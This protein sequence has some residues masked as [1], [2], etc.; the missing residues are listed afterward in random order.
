MQEIPFLQN[1]SP[2]PLPCAHGHGGQGQYPSAAASS[3][4]SASTIHV[5]VSSNQHDIVDKY[6]NANV[7]GGENGAIRLTL[8]TAP[9]D[10]DAAAAEYSSTSLLAI[11]DQDGNVNSNDNNIMP[12]L[13]PYSNT[14]ISTTVK[15][16]NSNPILHS[17]EP[18]SQQHYYTPSSALLRGLASMHHCSI[19]NRFIFTTG[20]VGTKKGLIRIS[21]KDNDFLDDEEEGINLTSEALPN[22]ICR[23][24][25]VD[26]SSLFES[27]RKDGVKLLDSTIVGVAVFVVS[28]PGA[29]S[30]SSSGRQDVEGGNWDDERMEEDDDNNNNN[31]AK[32]VVNTTQQSV[33]YLRAVDMYGTVLSLALSYPSLEPINDYANTT[34]G[35]A[36]SSSFLLPLSPTTTTCMGSGSSSRSTLLPHP[37][38]TIEYNQVCFPTPSTVV[39]ALNPHLYCVDFG[40]GGGKRSSRHLDHNHHPRTAASSTAT[41]SSFSG[42]A[43]AA[44]GEGK[45]IRVNTRVWTNLHVVTSDP[46]ADQ[47]LSESS[48]PIV[49]KKKKPRKSLGSILAMATYTIM[50]MPTYDADQEYE[51]PDEDDCDELVGNFEDGGMD[52]GHG[53]SRSAIPSIAA[54]AGLTTT[55]TNN[56]DAI[57]KVATLHSDGSLRIWI[58]EPSRTKNI[59]EEGGGKLRI[60]SV[61][62]IAIVVDED[63]GAGPRY[64]DPSI[65]N[66]SLWDP[67]RDALVLRGKCT[68]DPKSGTNEYECALY[69]QCYASRRNKREVSSRSVVHIFRGGIV[70]VTTRSDGEY[71]DDSTR[72][73]PSGNTADVQTLALPTDTT[74]V[75]DVSWSHTQDLIVMLRH[76]ALD[77]DGVSNTFYDI[78]E[79]EVDDDEVVLAIY[80]LE[81]SSC[82]SNEV[83][84]PSRLDLDYRG[85]TFGLCVEEELDRYMCPTTDVQKNH[86]NGEPECNN[87]A[88]ALSPHLSSQLISEA[89]YQLDRAGLL[90][91]LQPFGR[92]RP[93]VLAVYYAMSSLKLLDDGIGYDENLPVTIL[94]AMRKWKIQSAFHTSRAIVP[95]GNTGADTL[96]TP[97]ASKSLSIY[98]AFACATKTS[99]TRSTLIPDGTD[100]NEDDNV[101]KSRVYDV[102]AA[103]QSY[104]LKWIRFLSEIRRYEAQLD[105]VLCLKMSTSTTF[106]FR[107]SRVSAVSQGNSNTMA[108]V[109][110]STTMSRYESEIMA[111][112][113]ELA[114]DLFA[115]IT[116]N[117]ELRNQWSKVESF[118]YDGVSK[119][120]SL[121]DGWAYSSLDS[122]A[123]LSQVEMLGT[124]AMIKLVLTDSQIQLLSEMSQL[125]SDFTELW[126]MSPASESSSVCTRLSISKEFTTTADGIQRLCESD[127]I[128]S[129][130]ALVSSR[131]ESIRHLSLSRL[132]LVFGAPCKNPLIVQQSLRFTLYSTA[133]SWSVHQPSSKDNHMTVLEDSLSTLIPNKS[134][135]GIMATS[136]LADT[137]CSFA[138]GPNVHELPDSAFAKLIPV[139]RERRVA[140]RLLAP[141]VAFP[142]RLVSSEVKQKRMEVVVDCLL[143]EAAIVGSENF[144][145][146]TTPFSLWQLASKILVEATSMTN[147]VEALERHLSILEPSHDA[148]TVPNCCGVILEAVRDALGANESDADVPALWEIAFQVAMRGKLW[149]KALHACI[150]NP[151]AEQWQVNLKHLVLGMVDAGALGK[152]VDMSLP[153]VGQVV[154]PIFMQV[155]DQEIDNDESASGV[156]DLFKL[157]SEFIEEAAVEQSSGRP[158]SSDGHEVMKDRPNYWSCLYALHASR[159]NWRQATHA[160]DMLGKATVHSLSPAMSNPQKPQ[161]LSKAASRKVM[162]DVCLSSQACAHAIKLVHNPSHR[163]LLTSNEGISSE[164]RLLT[165]EDMERRATRALALRTLSMDENSP[166][167]VGSMLVSSS[168]D[169]IDSLARFGYYDHAISVSLGVSSKRGGCPGGL[170]LFDE[171]LNYILC[172][173]LVPAAIATSNSAQLEDNNGGLESLQLRSKIAQIRASS[174]TCALQS[175]ANTSIPQSHVTSFSSNCM[176]WASNRE[177]EKALQSSMAM[178]LLQQ[179]TIVHSKRCRGLG[180]NVARAILKEGNGMSNLPAWLIELCTFGLPGDGNQ[181]GG[182][183]VRTAEKGSGIADPAGLMRLLIQNHQYGEAC[184]VASSILSKRE[185]TSSCLRDT[186]A[187]SRLPEKGSIDYIPYDLID[188]LWDMIESI[189]TSHSPSFCKDVRSQVQSLTK[190]RYCLEQSLETHFE[191][192][193]LSEEGLVSARRLAS[194]G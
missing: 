83:V 176:S 140:L 24:R 106:L 186:G 77:C 33:L 95:V 142:P 188:M 52:M 71:D 30:P 118:L 110:D 161:A 46:I 138:F 36:A 125:S 89:E 129:A 14:T 163:Y 130:A 174:S 100:A 120:S 27:K 177:N 187:C 104:R 181:E 173:Y 107:G 164:S 64:V 96:N 70:G 183:F 72:A 10:K 131:L 51:Y 122:N 7:I 98:H 182:L 86:D 113:D 74:S 148:T 62:R 39:F 25:D 143:A 108:E 65:P 43:A 84:L 18:Q 3:S 141:F 119:A 149:D 103:Q 42:P 45:L 49:R 16:A 168:R 22:N 44:G 152:L 117:P 63:D 128:S 69:I 154:S 102:E 144:G 94:S 68:Y 92:S 75:V 11:T 48:T 179:Y 162:D 192:L 151:S 15:Q 60:P 35:G 137:F 116:S 134:I 184:D 8:T 180:L 165:E 159:G 20:I 167:S 32:V 88:I 5:T 193:K 1:H 158:W 78:V 19:D 13:L 67:S 2:L 9:S 50:G 194:V 76:R 178:D 37:G 29:S 126:L 81:S 4:M 191:S 85:D 61:Q 136:R 170:D 41:T 147:R 115:W 112:L 56:D 166:D 105:E 189:I 40:S 31:M 54:V 23:F 59:D 53:I 55:S 156:V 73:L 99:N 87:H 26:L 34:V 185:K 80:P 175:S 146:Q 82:Y 57:A 38:S 114:L 58:A 153:V 47:L 109:P 171:A 66:P 190:K 172:T 28:H 91:V 133:L 150:S 93:S 155:D 17:N 132:L 90:A 97:S 157:A 169:T 111:R 145:N 135:S 127:T 21:I 124:S 123:L 12:L 6:S 121:V 139:R 160:M 101:V 79:E